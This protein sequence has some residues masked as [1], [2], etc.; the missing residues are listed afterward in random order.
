MSKFSFRPDKQKNAPSMTRRGALILG[1]QGLLMGGLVWRMRDLQIEAGDEYRMLAEENRINVRLIPPARGEITD[2]KGRSLAINRQNYRVVMIREEAGD[3]EAVLDELG[4]LIEISP[5]Q[6]SRALREIRSKSAFVPVAVAEH[7][8]WEEFAQI[9]ANAPALPG[10]A[11]EV[12]LTRFYP[13]REV[14]GHVI[15]YV[16]RFTER[17]SRREDARDAL[18]QIPD[19]HIGKT[20]VERAVEPKLRGAAGASRIEVN[21]VGRV[22]REIDRTEGV[23]GAE[24]F[25]GLQILFQ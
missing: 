15:G 13:E 12:G 1:A 11:P 22:I 5:R 14:F 4:R 16:G 23:S 19:F 3:V 6:R 20:G 2:R 25:V 17:D 7:L 24:I 18:F 9:N 10:V 8:D 21:A